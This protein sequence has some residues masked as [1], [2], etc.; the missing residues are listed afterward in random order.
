VEG[1]DGSG[2]S[3]ADGALFWCPSCDDDDA[4]WLGR[5]ISARP[6]NRKFST[7]LK[8]L[9]EQIQQH[10]HTHTDALGERARDWRL[11]RQGFQLDSP[12]CYA[13]ILYVDRPLSAL[14]S[15]HLLLHCILWII[16]LS[17]EAAPS[18]PPLP[19]LRSQNV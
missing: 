11:A 3:E 7:Q 4:G 9:Q 13:T 8:S 18:P 16:G 19:L 17:G 12:E 5:N 1:C 6:W 2:G 14:T 15:Y 10:T